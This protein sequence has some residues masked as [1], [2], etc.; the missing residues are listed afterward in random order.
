MD[1]S[2]IN[3]D[4][5]LYDPSVEKKSITGR[6]IY[7]TAMYWM[8]PFSILIMFVIGIYVSSRSLK[9]GMDYEDK[10]LHVASLLVFWIFPLTIIVLLLFDDNAGLVMYCIMGLI[11]VS[12]L[13]L[14]VY[15]ISLE[16]DEITL[17]LSSTMVALSGIVLLM[18]AVAWIDK[19]LSRHG[20]KYTY[21]VDES[22]R[23][24]TNE[25][26]F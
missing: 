10:Y 1:Q 6:S 13:S 18:S 24:D 26:D 22:M 16:S 7:Y 4:D 23:F 20:V 15:Q 14:S 5:Y 17:G 21:G 19:L 8:I 12:I 2:T 9:V 3:I 25:I 11:V